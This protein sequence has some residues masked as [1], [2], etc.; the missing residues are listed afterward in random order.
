MRLRIVCLTA[1]LWGSLALARGE[2]WTG[3][4]A[5]AKCYDAEQRNVNPTDTLTFVDRDIG[6]MVR[7]C[8]PTARTKSFAIVL[9]GGRSLKLDPAGN[10]RAADLV[11]HSARKAVLT[12]SVSG[13]QNKDSIKVD[14]ISLSNASK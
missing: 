1:L 5:D 2:S 8:A 9:E 11:R 10:S 13:Q 3:P 4:L 6:L 14:S 7:Y 12:V